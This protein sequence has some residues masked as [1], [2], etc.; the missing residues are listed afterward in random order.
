MRRRISSF[1]HDNAAWWTDDTGVTHICESAAPL[2]NELLIWTLCDREVESGAAF[3]PSARDIVSCSKC[4]AAAGILERRQ[5]Q[6]DDRSTHLSSAD[7]NTSAVT[8]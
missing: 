2:N 3:A 7:G 1:I 4:A 5:A 6:R 8:S